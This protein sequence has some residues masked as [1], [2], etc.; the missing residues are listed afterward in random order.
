[1]VCI[2]DTF[3]TCSAASSIDEIVRS[4]RRERD[5]AY[6][7]PR[8]LLRSFAYSHLQGS[9]PCSPFRFANGGERGIR[10][11]GGVTHNGF[12]DRR[13]KPLCHLSAGNELYVYA[14]SMD[15]GISGKVAMVAAASKGIGFA[16]AQQLANEGCILSIC[17]RNGAEIE[18]AAAKL[19][20]KAKGY[21]VD[22][23]KADDLRSWYESTAGDLGTPQILVTNTGGPPAG[24]ASEM[25][26]EQWESGFQSTLLNVV[27]LVRLASPAMKERGWG[28]IVHITS[29]VAKDPSELL[30]ISSTLRSGLMALTK[31]QAKEMAQ[32]GVTVNGVLPGH[33]A[34]ARQVHLAEV[35]AEKENISLDEAM[36]LQAAGTAM[37][38]F[39][40]P[41]EIGA[42]VAFLCSTQA[43]YVSGVSLLVDGATT[44]SFG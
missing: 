9:T 30:P 2:I 44:T 42:A 5:G 26:D 13:I 43:S 25:T 8:S 37:K 15:F 4:W 40:D 17:A 7:H 1:M 23:T 14:P 22:V 33:T 24:H 18:A 27:R 31:L 29:L 20:A 16:S 41:R 35:R 11:P 19:G 10:T 28:R 34:T 6:G 39:A 3:Y 36:K 32:K 12:Q 38:R 21:V